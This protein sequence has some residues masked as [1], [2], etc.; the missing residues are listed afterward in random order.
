MIDYEYFKRIFNAIKGEPEFNVTFKNNKDVYMLIKYDEY[1]TYT[2]VSDEINIKEV[3]YK[4][5]DELYNIVLINCWSNIEDIVIDTIYSV[6]N[7]L[8]EIERIFNIEKI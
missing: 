2:K 5:L 8:D 3:K 7:D 6:V 1:V 4:D